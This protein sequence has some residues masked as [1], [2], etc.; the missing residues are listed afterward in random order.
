MVNFAAIILCG[1]NST[2]YQS[3]DG[4]YKDKQLETIGG[5]P[6]FIHS[7]KTFLPLAKEVIVVIPSGKKKYLF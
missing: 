4:L 2:R 3:D 5:I 6:V 1:G 7:I